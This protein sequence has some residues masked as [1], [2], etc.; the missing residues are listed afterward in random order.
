MKFRA[1]ISAIARLQ[2]SQGPWI[3]GTYRSQR[4]EE[5]QLQFAIRHSMHMFDTFETCPERARLLAIVTTDRAN[6]TQPELVLSEAAEAAGEQKIEMKLKF[7]S[8]ISVSLSLSPPVCL[9]PPKK[10]DHTFV[11]ESIFA[12]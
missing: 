3:S 1:Y 9:F 7:P 8:P 2:K 5:K 11:F 12:A 4:Q 10:I 6:R